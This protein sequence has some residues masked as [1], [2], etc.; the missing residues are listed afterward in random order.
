MVIAKETNLSDPC[1]CHVQRPRRLGLVEDVLDRLLGQGVERKV[2]LLDVDEHVGVG[3]D[4]PDVVVGHPERVQVK[5]LALKHVHRH[6]VE[7]VVAEVDALQLQDLGLVEHALWHALNLVVGE[8]EV[9]PDAAL[10]RVAQ[11]LTDAVVT[12]VDEL[13]LR[14]VL[15]G[16]LTHGLDLVV[17]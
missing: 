1:P 3:G 6:P 13:Q 10:E 11:Q 5:V 16:R 14:G 7:L 2:D 9:E 12:E 4:V 15:E 8:V 17:A